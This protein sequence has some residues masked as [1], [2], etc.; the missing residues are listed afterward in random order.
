MN[1]SVISIGNDAVDR[2]L[3]RFKAIRYLSTKFIFFV[4]EKAH[5][6]YLVFG[7]HARRSSSSFDRHV[8]HIFFDSSLKQMRRSNA[9]W[10]ITMM[11]NIKAIFDGAFMKYPREAMSLHHFGMVFRIHN[12]TVSVRK[13]IPS[14]EPASFSLFDM[15]EKQLFSRFTSMMVITCTA[16][17]RKLSFG[18]ISATQTLIN[19]ISSILNSTYELQ[20]GRD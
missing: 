12:S 9:G 18:F 4:V 8:F 15:P 17:A 14:P 11:A 7:E 5:C 10:V 19:H 2:M 3:I 20:E 16:Q 13:S 6:L 1:I